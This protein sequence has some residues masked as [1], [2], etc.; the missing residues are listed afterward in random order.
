MA[1][2][3]AHTVSRRAADLL[4]H[5]QAKRGPGPY[6]G[7]H[8]YP[9]RQPTFLLPASA[10]ASR[11]AI[12]RSL[13]TRVGWP[14]ARP[15]SRLARCRPT[16]GVPHHATAGAN[17]TCVRPAGLHTD[18]TLSISQCQCQSDAGAL[19]GSHPHLRAPGSTFCESQSYFKR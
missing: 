18:A 5:M 9:G 14:E 19:T 6:C 2:A 16:A 11:E 1:T 3:R 7:T 12:V 17:R 10:S 15:S 4:T 13:L 8:T